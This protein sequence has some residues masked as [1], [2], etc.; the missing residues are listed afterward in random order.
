MGGLMAGV[1]GFLLAG[2]IVGYLTSGDNQEVA[3]NGMIVGFVGGHYFHINWNSN[4]QFNLQSQCFD[5]QHVS[6]RGSYGWNH[7]GHYLWNHISNWGY[8]WQFI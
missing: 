5:V 4:E 2:I 8:H 7:S 3:I 6:C 1:V